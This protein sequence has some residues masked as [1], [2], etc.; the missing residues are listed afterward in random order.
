M[1]PGVGQGVVALAQRSSQA[2]AQ[3]QSVGKCNTSRRAEEAIRAGTAIRWVRRVAHPALA[4]RAGAAAPAARRLLK[5]RQARVSSHN[6]AAFAVNFPEGAGASGPLFSSA[7]LSMTCSM[8]AW[9]PVN[10]WVSS[11]LT[12][13][14][15]GVGDESVVTP[16]TRRW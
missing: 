15:G 11:A 13:L 2:G 9:S 10:R 12:V 14:T 1:G 7:C 16:A 6:Q 5:A 8:T 4:C 3:G